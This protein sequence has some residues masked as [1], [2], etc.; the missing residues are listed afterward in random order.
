MS[1]SPPTASVFVSLGK[2]TKSQLASLTRAHLGPVGCG[3][4]YN[5]NADKACT[6]PVANHPDEVII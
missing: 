4:Y 5:L 2:Y 6:W 1:S 3:E